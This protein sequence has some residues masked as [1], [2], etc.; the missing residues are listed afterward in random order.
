MMMTEIAPGKDKIKIEVGMVIETDGRTLGIPTT[1]IGVT[2]AIQIETFIE[3][4]GEGL[5]KEITEDQVKIDIVVTI[6]IDPMTGTQA[7]ETHTQNKIVDMR[8]VVMTGEDPEIDT[9]MII[10]LDQAE[11]KKEIPR[12]KMTEGEIGRI[13][14][15]RRTDRRA[16]DVLRDG[17]TTQGLQVGDVRAGR[18]PPSLQQY[19]Q[20]TNSIRD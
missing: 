18:L 17:M 4:I 6:E 2:V 3:T 20:M 14:I 11:V 15:P 7:I 1:G 16:M 8:E 9:G 13:G 10:D 5:L 19:T 12:Q